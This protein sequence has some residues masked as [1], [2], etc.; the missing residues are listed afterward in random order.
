MK[1]NVAASK[2]KLSSC[3]AGL[4]LYHA[5]KK[6]LQDFPNMGD[7]QIDIQYEESDYPN[8]TVLSSLYD[9]VQNRMELKVSSQNPIRHL[10]SN[11]QNNIFLKG[12]LLIFQ[13]IMNDTSSTLDN[14][15]EYFRTM[16]SPI[17]F[18]PVLADWFGIHLNT[19]GGED[20]VRQF[21]Q[22]AIP[23]YRYRGTAIGLKAYLAIITKIVPEIIEE[24]KPYFAMVMLEKAETDASLFESDKNKH[25]ISIYFPVERNYF[26][27]ALIRRISLVVQQ[28]KPVYT[29]AYITFK[30]TK[31]QKRKVTMIETNESMDRDGVIFI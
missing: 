4:N 19:L 9:N 27:D 11:Y 29:E 17:T 28:E 6:I 30:Q 16:E 8:F 13:H 23:L 10:P 7:K 26:D 31:K 12:F 2:E 22:Y 21:L 25:Y 24:T 18:L 15:H 5:R 3:Y 20:E 14:M 1:I